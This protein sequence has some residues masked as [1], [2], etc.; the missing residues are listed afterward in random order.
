MLD[1]TLSV[2]GLPLLSCAGVNFARALMI[3]HVALSS[4]ED[5]LDPVIVQFDTRPS[6]LTSSRKLVRPS[7]FAARAEGG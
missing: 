3:R 6:G 5:P 2:V 1:E 7:W 4:A